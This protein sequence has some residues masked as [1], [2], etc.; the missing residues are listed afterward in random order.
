M[1]ES[2]GLEEGLKAFLEESKELL[3]L[4]EQTLLQLEDSPENT[5]LIG[6]LFRSIHTIKGSAGIFGFDQVVA[7][8]HVAESVM[9]RVREQALSLSNELISTLLDAR[10]HIVIL[11]ECAL[12]ETDLPAE[13]TTHGEQLLL[14]LKHFLVE[15]TGDTSEVE[16]SANIVVEVPSGEEEPSTNTFNEAASISEE[17]TVVNDCWHLSLRFSQSVLQGGMDPSSFFRYLSTVGDVV[18]M[19]TI[20]EGLLDFMEMNPEDC[21]LGFEIDLESA[22]SKEEIAAVFE[23]VEDDCSLHILPPHSAL[24]KYKQLINELPEEKFYLGE[25]LVKSG[26]LTYRELVEVLAAQDTLR[27][28]LLANVSDEHNEHDKNNSKA[29]SSLGVIAIE[30]GM[31]STPIVDAALEKQ[32]QVKTAQLQ[33]QQTIRVSPQKLGYLIDLV[34][35]LVIASAHINVQ[36]K[37][38]GDDTLIESGENMTWLVD[39]IREVSLG[40]RM[41]PIG[42]TFNRYKRIVRDLSKGLNKNID[43]K[44]EG[45][46][47]ELDKTVVEKIADPLM[48]MV[49]NAIDHGIETPDIRSAMGKPKTATLLLRAYHESGNVSIEISDD[50]RGLDREKILAKANQ[51][52]LLKDDKILSDQEVYRLIFEPGF[53]TAEE[54]SNISGRGVGM[55]VVRRNVESLRGQI[56]VSSTLG[57]GSAFTIRL[58][59]TLAIIDGFQ[60]NVAGISYIIPLGM[61]DECIELNKKIYDS[62]SGGNYINLRGEV[63]PYVRLK[64]LFDGSPQ[65]YTSPLTTTTTSNNDRE[66]IVVVQYAGK[67]AGLVVDELLGE[68]QAV[69][70]PLGKI[71]KNLECISGAT[72]LGGG[73]VAMIIDVPKLLT[74]AN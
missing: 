28:D 50:G 5:D 56:D 52:G 70:K 29:V 72:I 31:V 73:D 51:N 68:Q 48:H 46:D 24:F 71:F 23:F 36:A 8:T 18:T 16:A 22:A 45:G 44:I 61:I 10:D 6:E 47:T 27:Q 7:F 9:G 42:D 33:Q 63:L 41:V 3:E 35:E 13:A 74:L 39:Q 25:M 15:T 4:A 30:K 20:E 17:N 2:D 53:S 14:G 62:G 43:F 37:N 58:P 60:V 69:I 55:D 38:N 19:T 11:L 12:N 34:G 66:N 65:L 26:A 59:L 49:R 57:K 32:Q 1:S 64:Q 21:Y 67:K 40:L 54:V